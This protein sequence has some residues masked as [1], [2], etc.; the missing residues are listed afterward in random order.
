MITKGGS[1]E[2]KQIVKVEQNSKRKCEQRTQ[3][4]LTMSVHGST[5]V[6][7]CGLKQT[8]KSDMTISKNKK[9][10]PNRRVEH[11]GLMLNKT[12]NNRA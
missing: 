1:E 10:A 3:C 9:T 2:K 6:S 11:Y 4:D 12:R 7:P 8:Q 5:Y